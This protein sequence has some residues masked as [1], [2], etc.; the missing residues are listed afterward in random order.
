MSWQLGNV[1]HLTV[2]AMPMGRL[3]KA[4]ELGVYAY[5]YNSLDVEAA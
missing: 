1:M 3:L 5:I 4:A 2:V